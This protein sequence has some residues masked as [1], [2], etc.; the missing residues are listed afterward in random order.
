[1]DEL[2][3]WMRKTPA[4][5]W[6]SLFPVL[7]GLAIVYAGYKVNHNKWMYLGGS[8]VALAFLFSAVDFF[9]TLVWIAQIATA[10]SL[11][12]QFLRLQ[13]NN[14]HPSMRDASVISR[15]NFHKIDINDCSK[16]DL[17]RD[18]G[19]PI[20]YANDIELAKK[21]GYIFTHL[22]EL[23]DVAGLPTNYVNKLGSL[24]VFRYDLNKEGHISWRRLNTFTDLQ[25]ID[26]GLSREDAR[27]IVETRAKSGNFS[28][29]VDMLKKTGLSLSSCQKIL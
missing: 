26:C 3:V 17:V 12:S 28:S 21:E 4:W 5:T 23:T 7:G 24:V 22:E 20:V 13:G 25:L 16:D 6:F 19:I 10:F 9:V 29:V 14:T 15:D 18:L 27:L 1:M 8:F 2:Q 11:R